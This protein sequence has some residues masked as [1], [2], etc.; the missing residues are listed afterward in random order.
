MNIPTIEWNVAV[1]E[2]FSTPARAC[3]RQAQAPNRWSPDTDSQP[4]RLGSLTSNMSDELKKI[5][6]CRLYLI[7]V[8]RAHLQC[9]EKRGYSQFVRVL[10]LSNSVDNPIWQ[11]LT[12]D[13]LCQHSRQ[14]GITISGMICFSD[15]FCSHEKGHGMRI[16][17]CG[18]NPKT[19]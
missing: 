19:E 15:K 2:H 1:D 8:H 18:N 14:A 9:K 13:E 7:D 3:A 5:D 6:H 12:C 4:M 16:L 10:D 11:P 17:R